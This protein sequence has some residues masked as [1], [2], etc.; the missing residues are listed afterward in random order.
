MEYESIKNNTGISG[1]FLGIKIASGALD[2]KYLTVMM[3][4]NRMIY[5]QMISVKASVINF[6]IKGDKDLEYP[7]KEYAY[8]EGKIGNNYSRNNR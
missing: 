1:K 6:L 5:L 8:F 2:M 4:E 3:I 7:N